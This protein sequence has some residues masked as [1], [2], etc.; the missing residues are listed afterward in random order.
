MAV[1]GDIDREDQGISIVGG[2]EDVITRDEIDKG[3]RVG[4]AELLDS[5]VCSES[6]SLVYS[7]GKRR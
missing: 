4:K 6:Q 3:D 5:G 1:D 2:G 7:V